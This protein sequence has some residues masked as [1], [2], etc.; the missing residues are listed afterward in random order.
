MTEIFL[1][2][3]LIDQDKLEEL[4]LIRQKLISHGAEINPIE[5]SKNLA[6]SFMSVMSAGGVIWV[7]SNLS[8]TL[9]KRT[10]LGPDRQRQRRL[11]YFE[12]GIG[13]R[14]NDHG[15]SIGVGD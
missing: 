5:S 4:D 1:T 10:V 3:E 7:Q 6:E 9:N 15:F 2:D 14:R 12:K 13:L 8:V 11:Q